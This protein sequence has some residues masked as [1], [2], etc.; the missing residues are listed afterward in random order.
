MNL[1]YADIAWGLSWVFVWVLDRLWIR[2]ANGWPVSEW[3]Y[4]LDWITFFFNGFAAWFSIVFIICAVDY[5][6]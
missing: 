3:Y 6:T 5:F 1:L 2:A 4:R